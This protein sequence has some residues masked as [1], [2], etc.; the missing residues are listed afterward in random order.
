MASV[1]IPD[2]EWERV[3][4]TGSKPGTIG[5]P[6]PGVT[7]RAVDPETGGPVPEG[8]PG[9]LHVK[10]P[11]V[12]KGYVGDPERTAESLRDG[13]YVTGDVGIIDADGFVTI[14]DRLSRFSK[15]AGEMVSHAAVE[16][17]LQEAAGEIE[18]AFA[19]TSIPDEAR[20]ETLAAFYVG[21][22]DVEA[23]RS[24]LEASLPRL[25]IP[26]SRRFH[27]IDKLPLL[28][29]GKLDLAGLKAA[30]LELSKG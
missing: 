14:T 15:I 30:A 6:L 17:R 20:G 5:Q 2:V 4:Q 12:M 29:S 18:P 19:V 10:G 27:K 16:M 13:Y 9:V 23:L 22:R 24:A 26:E 28:A 3:Q 7:I 1:N 21:E 8:S 25:W 11:N